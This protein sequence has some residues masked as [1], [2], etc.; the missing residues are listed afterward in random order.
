MK[1]LLQCWLNIN[2][3]LITNLSHFGILRNLVLREIQL[4][5][6]AKCNLVIIF[7]FPGLLLLAQSRLSRTFDFS[8]LLAVGFK[9][10][11]QHL[12]PDLAPPNVRISASWIYKTAMLTAEFL[13]LKVHFWRASKIVRM[14][15]ILCFCTCSKIMLSHGLLNCSFWNKL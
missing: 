9:N 14:I 10:V 5:D 6:A 15:Y 7:V 12:F 1:N 2:Q 8:T 4:S 13:E 3:L 11:W